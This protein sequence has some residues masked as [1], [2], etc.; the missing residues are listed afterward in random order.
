MYKKLALA[1]LV[2][3]FIS[4]C[5]GI[6]VVI[7]V[8]ASRYSFDLFLY[9]QAYGEANTAVPAD[10]DIA[11]MRRGLHINASASGAVASYRDEVSGTFDIEF[12]PYSSVSYGGS[13]YETDLYSN[14]YQDINSMSLVFTDSEDTG[15][16]FRVKLTGG[17]NGNNVTV[18]ASVIYEDEQAG[19]YY[20]NDN[21]AGGS[22]TGYNEN[23][24]YTFLY[25]CSFSNVA[26]AN[27]VYAAENVRP[28][29]IVFDPT[30]MK[31]YGYHYGYNA[32][33]AEQ[34]LI[35]DF[36]SDI[37]DGRK[38]DFTLDSFESYHVKIVFDDIKVGTTGNIIVYSINGQSLANTVVKNSFGPVCYLGNANN[39]EIG[40]T[41]QISA[42]KCYDV[43]S[44]A[45]PFNGLV[46]AIDPDSS[47]CT[48]AGAEVAEDG[49]YVYK[50]GLSF[51]CD[52][53]GEYLFV[54]KAADEDGLYGDEYTVKFCADNVFAPV[55][56]GE[57]EE[58]YFSVND[59]LTLAETG[60]NINESV[61]HAESEVFDPA[62]KKLTAPYI[63]SQ[64]GRYTVVCSGNFE[65]KSLTESYY[66]YALRESDGLFQG[67]N[68]AVTGYGNSGLHADLNGMIA[69]AYVSNSVFMYTE[70]IRISDKTKNDTMISLMAL[71]EHF[72]TASFGQI[73]IKL[74]DASN[75][76]N[77]VTVI[78]N[79][80][81][82]Q[83]TSVIRAA[84]FNQTFS[85]LNNNGVI[86]SFSGGGTRILHSFAGVSRYENI[87]GQFIDIR[88]DNEEKSI[89]AGNKL[90]CD[91]DDS[92]HFSTIWDGFS[93]EEVILSVTVRDITA[94]RC[95]FL[96]AQIDGK[97]FIGDYYRE[98]V[99]PK[100]RPSFD[101]NHIPKALVG[102]EYEILPVEIY[103]N[104]KENA[105]LTVSV[106]DETG[107]SLAVS[108]NKFVPRS[109][110]DYILRYTVINAMGN[111]NSVEYIVTAENALPELEIV[112]NAEFS[113][114]VYVGETIQLPEAIIHGGAGGT[115]VYITA[116]GKETG[117]EYTVTEFCFRALVEDVYTVTYRAI[118]YLNQTA[119]FTTEID[120]K[121]S[122]SPIF[123][124]FPEMPHVFISGVPV[125]LPAV[126]AM[127]YADGEQPAEVEISVSVDGKTVTVD[128]GTD[129]TASID[130]DKTTARVTY[131]AKGQKGTAEAYFDIPVINLRDENG[132]LDLTRYFLTQN[133]GKITPR[134]DCISFDIQNDAKISFIK[135]VYSHGFEL[136]FDIPASANNLNGFVLTLTDS[137][138]KSK[139][140]VFEIKKGGFEDPFTTVTINGSQ[141][142]VI[143]GNFYDA[144]RHMRIAY[145]NDNYSLKDATGLTVGNI[146][147]YADG[148]L[149]RGFSET[150]NFTIEF[151]TVDGAARF[152]LYTVGNQQ[153]MEN[154]D[155]YTRPVVILESELHRSLNKGDILSIPAAKAYDVLGFTT[156]ITVSVTCG[157]NVLLSNTSCNQSYSVKLDAYGEY[158]VLYRA[159]D[160][161][162]NVNN[163]L[164]VVNVRDNVPPQIEL[165]TNEKVIW[166]GDSFDI[167]EARLSDDVEID[168]AYV[169]VIDTSNNM[170]NVTGQKS[171]TTTKKGIYILRYVAVDKAGNY[172]IVD[173]TIKAAET[174]K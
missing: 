144:I 163:F 20:Y 173:V 76:E 152:D 114:S 41:I 148:R 80:G 150:I 156:E 87:C 9:E 38:V 68:G 22:T 2:A 143:V 151:G 60:W 91:F 35:W 125:T 165:D 51:I 83:D 84:A 74:Q 158:N 61:I 117:T 59:T 71:P 16:S 95:R 85:G 124:A 58:K 36:S 119:E 116:Q 77:F 157:E 162:G 14:T 97:E 109:E 172:R 120:V 133:I 81:T 149:F 100:I 138:D 31:V 135:S 69:E 113:K 19:I 92:E 1:V 101:E 13:V 44:G 56:F 7:S 137:A 79:A 45:V 88:F 15:K 25:G 171:F 47:T 166:A 18:N 123:G 67:T 4:C 99:A 53:Q 103:G 126:T 34:R 48:I 39:V 33:S 21:P 75:E 106:F 30:E 108:Q 161:N 129:F 17:A 27:G 57:L 154:D 26:V 160:D 28:V 130:K 3:I 10:T 24:V 140:V 169:F 107:N 62:N 127:D 98:Y 82:E 159:E 146:K 111:S 96:V 5:A 93:S 37:V 122:S 29:R 6:G 43:V 70:P 40:E 50:T 73:S 147:N 86:E 145:D 141:D 65:G 153:F 78:I 52:K 132:Y 66:I 110:G 49:F 139:Q 155:D 131:L 23:G 94:E 72:G 170:I 105:M 134:E 115:T 42:P 54:Y 112:P 32:Y 168:K 167:A 104:D 174:E 102:I 12:M 8:N 164:L 136:M 89:Y 128:D 63:L 55:F 64:E 11:E 118:D 90:V 121:L 142:I 46:K